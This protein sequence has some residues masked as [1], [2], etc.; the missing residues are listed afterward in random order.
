MR[1]V[2]FLMRLAKDEDGAHTTEIALAVGLFALVAGFGFFTYG[3]A[4][5][6]F[7]VSLADMYD[8]G[9]GIFPPPPENPIP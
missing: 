2:S 3:D 6:G 7:F 8:G 9:M 1:M 4:L 5:A